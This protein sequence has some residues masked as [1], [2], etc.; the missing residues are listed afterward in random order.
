LLYHSL[1]EISGRKTMNNEPERIHTIRTNFF[2]TIR[3]LE[4][5]IVSA[6]RTVSHI[7][8]KF[9]CENRIKTYLE[10][11]TKQ[12]D[13]FPSLEIALDQGNYQ[14]VGRICYLVV[15]LSHMVKEDAR[16]L[17]Q[18]LK[19]DQICVQEYLH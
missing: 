13:L 8:D 11:V 7:E 19:T 3:D 6:Q 18:E 9:N 12:K 14:E 5:A 4:K 10:I 15:H 2:E 1:R 17:I 16:Q